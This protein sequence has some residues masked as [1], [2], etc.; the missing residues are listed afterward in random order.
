MAKFTSPLLR[1]AGALS[2]LALR[3]VDPNTPASWRPAL[4]Q[5]LEQSGDAELAATVAA[6]L[7]CELDVATRSNLAFALRRVVATP[8][9][10]SNSNA[11]SLGLR[12]ESAI[13]RGM[14]LKARA[15]QAARSPLRL[16]IDDEVVRAIDENDPRIIEQAL[17]AAEMLKREDAVEPALRQINHAAPTVR[18]AAL[19]LVHRIAP[20]RLSGGAPSGPLAALVNDSDRRVAAL[21]R[22]IRSKLGGKSEVGGKP[23]AAD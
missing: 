7:E 6:L 10:A 19:R 3:L 23:A 2:V 9:D 17:W 21:A 20:A 22:S 18:L 1:Q 15:Y 8:A 16:A 4:A 13:V 5:A 14:A 12:D 11:L